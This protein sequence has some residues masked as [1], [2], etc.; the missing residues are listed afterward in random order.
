MP[1]RNE[2]VKSQLKKGVKKILLLDII[3]AL[4]EG[5]RPSD[6]S[7]DLNITKQLLS[8]YM[9]KLKAL[10]YIK[11]I[12]YGV[13]EVQERS[14]KLTKD[15]LEVRGHAFMWKVRLPKIKNWNKRVE[16]LD[17]LNIRYKLIGAY[18]KTPRIILKDRKIWLGDRYL[19][20]YEPKS[21]LGRNA[22]ESKNYAVQGLMELL[23][24]LESKFKVSFKIKGKYN[25]KVRR[26]HYALIKNL[27]AKQFNRE[28]KKIMIF[29]EGD[30]WFIIDNSYN[31]EEAETVSKKTAVI[32][33]L[34]FQ[35]YMNSHK[36][37]NFEVTPDFVLKMMH[38]IQQNQLMFAENMRSHIEAIRKLGNEVENLSESIKN[39]SQDNN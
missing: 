38:G 37:T 8:Y 33:N 30:L 29:H 10:G 32:D 25:F 26:H 3:N 13:W 24:L 15:T 17:K 11:K 35:E 16:I 9:G 7:K 6:I 23:E 12:G 2:E 22:I 31:L 27:I 20:I 28:N 18:K 1:K 14:K 36:R 19:I 4:K 39:V 34:G 21:F 5:K